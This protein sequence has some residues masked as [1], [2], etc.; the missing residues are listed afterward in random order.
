MNTITFIVSARRTPH[1][2]SK[3][4]TFWGSKVRST[5]SAVAAL[6][7]LLLLVLG[8][9]GQPA[10]Y[11]HQAR[12]QWTALMDTPGADQPAEPD[13]DA[14][15]ERE[16]R[17]EQQVT[18][19][20][21]ELAARQAPPPAAQPVPPAALPQPD[22]PQPPA[23]QSEVAGSMPPQ[24]APPQAVTPQTAPPQAVTPQTEAVLPDQPVAAVPP[25]I[26]IPDRNEFTATGQAPVGRVPPGPAPDEPARRTAMASAQPAKPEVAKP[27]VAKPEVAKPEVAKPEPG[28]AGPNRPEPGKAAAQKL[29][30]LKPVPAPPP[31]SQ[32]APPRQ[33]QDPAQSV[34]ARLRQLAPASPPAQQPIPLP[35]A[36]PRPRLAPSPSLPKL[37]AARAALAS[38]RVED[39]RRLL[40]EVQLQLVFRPVNGAGDEAPSAGKG[41][42]DVAHAL[43]ALSG[44]DTALSRRYID[45]A[46]EDLS[47]AGTTT[48]MQETQMRASGYA[49]AYPPR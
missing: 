12:Q 2:S 9:Y 31:L 24:A 32:P 45:V 43:E 19:L 4:T 44:N 30:V 14:Q 27:E 33:E 7:G 46:V 22:P 48:P 39:A 10:V 15:A 29:A 38:G 49:P 23:G 41:A 16:A 40:Q 13:R 8:F 35:P 18:R 17:L 21:D 28:K 42:A 34:L 11:L 6:S 37:T 25:A 3:A 47:G 5:I 36:D 20:E 26:T 1:D